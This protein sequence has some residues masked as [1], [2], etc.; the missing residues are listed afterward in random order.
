MKTK[1]SL[2]SLSISDWSGQKTAVIEGSISADTPLS[3]IVDQAVRAM[4]LPQNVPYSLYTTRGGNREVK[5]NQSDTVS[6]AKLEASS[7][8]MLSQEVQAG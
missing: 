3:E 7:E 6:E 2:S 8:L 4:D 1:R 5:L